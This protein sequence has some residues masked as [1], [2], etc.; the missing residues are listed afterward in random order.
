MKP[1]LCCVC[2]EAHWSR[3]GHRFA[4]K[5]ERSAAALEAG[6]LVDPDRPR[7]KAPASDEKAKGSGERQGH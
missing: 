4:A 7:T 2:G 5:A 6:R 3:E 1:P